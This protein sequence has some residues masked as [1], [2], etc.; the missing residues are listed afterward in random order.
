MNR[1]FSQMSWHGSR[2][3]FPVSYST[4]HPELG[5]VP[6]VEDN[7]Y[8]NMAAGL[9]G[10]VYYNR[11]FVDSLDRLVLYWA[12]YHELGH[13]AHKDKGYHVADS[14]GVAKNW[15]QELRADLFAMGTIAMETP[16]LVGLVGT[17]TSAFLKGL[18]DNASA[19]H[20]PNSTRALNVTTAVQTV[21]DGN[22]F[23]IRL[24]DSD[25]V[26]AEFV[27]RLVAE[28]NREP[29]VALNA[30]TVIHNL[31]TKKTHVFGPMNLHQAARTK[32]KITEFTQAN[33]QQM[34]MIAQSVPAF[35]NLGGFNQQIVLNTLGLR[36]EIVAVKT[37][38]V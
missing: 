34:Q 27:T 19:T 36:P 35:S 6:L 30:E 7:N 1:F 18:G 29:V 26:S 2:A 12:F 23:A 25:Y 3:N 31:N 22:T 16:E 11:A 5:D 20:P 24:N 15:G 28:L 8:P 37:A 10:R 9:D 13:L 14:S 17:V 32:A 4:G 21:S 38:K 33:M